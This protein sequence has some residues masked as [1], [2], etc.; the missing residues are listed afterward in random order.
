MIG[1]VLID[2]N[3]LVLLIVGS[4]SRSLISGH[5]RLNGY[6]LDDFDQLTTLLGGFSNII[7][8][9]HVL[10]EVSNLLDRTARPNQRSILAKFVDFIDS[11]LECS[12]PSNVVITRPEF[13]ILGLTDAVLLHVCAQDFGGAAATLLTTDHD[14]AN[15]ASSLGYGVIDFKNDYMDYG[16]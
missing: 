4:A 6:S 10:A 12:I 7:T 1:P 8:V 14:L 13:E 16:T 5:R 15:Y 3:L 9:P 2:T 11:T